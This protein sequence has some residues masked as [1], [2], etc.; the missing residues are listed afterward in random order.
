MDMKRFVIVFLVTLIV[1]PASLF[2]LNDP[3]RVEQGQLSGTTGKNPEVRVYKGI[4]YAAPP[5]GDLRWKPPQR[6]A[7]WQGVREAKE[8]GNACWQAP[9]PAN[10][11]YQAKLPPLS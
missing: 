3:I 4:P 10:S 2:A 5:V 1:A 8:Y 6:A 7:S 11:F 9:Y